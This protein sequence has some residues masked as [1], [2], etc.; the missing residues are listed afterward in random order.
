MV[1][2]F[3]SH[4]ITKMRSVVVS[5]FNAVMNQMKSVVCDVA[6]AITRFWSAVMG[7]V[8]LIINTI[9]NIITMIW[10]VVMVLVL[11]IIMVINKSI[12]YTE[13]RTK[14]KINTNTNTN[15]NPKPKPKPNQ[16]PNPNPNPN[17]PL[18]K[19]GTK[20]S[21]VDKNDHIHEQGGCCRYKYNTEDL[22]VHVCVHK[23]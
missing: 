9:T 11:S 21:N 8:Q 14:K 13:Y 12:T 22:C 4:A 10:S 6:G 16:N 1:A 7:L 18:D 5:V 19:G 15:P 17:A 20:C 2:E 23:C 3:S